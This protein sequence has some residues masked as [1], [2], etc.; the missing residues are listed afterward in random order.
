[1]IRVYSVQ[2]ADVIIRAGN[3]VQGLAIV[4]LACASAGALYQIIGTR[5]A[6]TSEPPGSAIDLSGR[7]LHVSTSGAGTPAVLFEAGIAASSLRWA[8][9]QAPAPA[10][11]GTR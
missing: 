4:L 3:Y 6:R 8:H 9:V 5:R 11:A 2:L 7:R 10:F 1:T